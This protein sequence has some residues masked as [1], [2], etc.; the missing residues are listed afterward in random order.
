MALA[1]T[2]MGQ[3]GWL[4][5][6]RLTGA[7]PDLGEGILDYLTEEIVNPDAEA[8]FGTEYLGGYYAPI[9][10]SYAELSP[11]SRREHQD[12]SARGTVNDDMRVAA[13]MLA[14][15][16]VDSYDIW[17]DAD[18]DLRWMIH[19]IQ[20]LEAVSGVPVAVAAELRLIPFSHVI[21]KLPIPGQLPF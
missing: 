1:R 19:K 12:L 10:N 14:V 16:Q 2:R 20:E 3:N 18:S 17:V 4:L 13:R 5:K 21:Y 6:R 9:P 7:R 11:M 15:P 8:T